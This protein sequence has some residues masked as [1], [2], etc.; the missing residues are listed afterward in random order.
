MD[1]WRHQRIQIIVRSVTI[2][3]IKKTV[4]ALLY[5]FDK[6]L[7]TKDMQEYTFIP[8]VGMEPKEFWGQSIIKFAKVKK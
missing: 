2:I 4:I 5:D 1:I 8:G 3:A 6:T 7:C